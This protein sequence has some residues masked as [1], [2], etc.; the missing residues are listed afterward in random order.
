[1]SE[2]RDMRA[3]SALVCGLPDDRLQLIT[4]WLMLASAQAGCV[5]HAAPVTGA[6]HLAHAMFVEVTPAADQH[7]GELTVPGGRVDLIVASEH[8]ELARAV[9]AGFADPLITTAI[10]S[11]RRALTHAEQEAEGDLVLL[12]Q[13]IDAA[14]ERSCRRYL[15]FNAAQVSSWY[16]LPPEATPGLLFGALAGS[17]AVGLDADACREA[18]LRLGVDTA[19]QLRAFDVGVRMGKRPSGRVTRTQTADQFVR[20]QRSSLPRKQRAEFEALIARIETDIEPSERGLVRMM[21]A[22]L[23][24]FHSPT[25]AAV[26]LDACVAIQRTEQEHPSPD[27]VSLVGRAARSIAQTMVYN[28]AAHSA[29]IKSSRSRLAELRKRHGLSRRDLYSVRDWMLLDR[30][31]KLP[32]TQTEQEPHLL[33]SVRRVSISPTTLRGMMRLRLIAR[34]RM[35]REGSRDYEA[36]ISAA[37]AF[38]NA[39]CDALRVDHDL[40]WLVAGSGALV[41]GSEAVREGSLATAVSFWGHVVSQSAS[42]DRAGRNPQ[43]SVTRM[44]VPH[45]YYD[46]CLRGPLMLWDAV[47]VVVGAALHMSR[48]GSYRHA[49]EHIAALCGVTVE[50]EETTPERVVTVDDL[51]GAAEI[52]A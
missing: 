30:T 26:G 39:V 40:A 4:D 22:D 46:L 21:V 5:M 49:H 41:Y 15:S 13:D 2:R 17:G 45:V 6:P 20:K 9:Q 33:R 51:G 14:V 7:D 38:Q 36:A 10:A 3:W 25:Y 1:M 43:Y 19:L 50:R 8:M 24:R 16:Q 18:M 48:G 34:Q 31:S 37:S 42:I 11:T 32:R 27:G 29:A 52:S 35:G 44:L 23:A 47:G 28:D 12:E